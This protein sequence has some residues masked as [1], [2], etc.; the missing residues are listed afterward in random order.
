M[1]NRLGQAAAFLLLY[2]VALFVS[3]GTLRWDRAWIFLGLVVAA[4]TVTAFVLVRTNPEVIRARHLPGRNTIGFD[5]IIISLYVPMFL[6]LPVVAGLDAVRYHWSSLPFAT[7]YP[8]AA[9][10]LLAFL[11]SAWALSVNPFAETSV[12]L[13]SER[14]QTVISA[15]PYRFVRHPMYVGII[16][17]SFAVPLIL[18][19]AWA[20]VPGAAIDILIVVRTAL[21]D[22]FLSRELPGYAEF[23]QRTRYRLV[24]GLW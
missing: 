21:E 13:Q 10:Y 1:L 12:R 23:A 7:V 20:F 15:G 11:P 14:G 6:A 18:G 5:K 2:A 17:S 9:L 16:V 4:L 3:A 8:G 19:S 22:R 24:P